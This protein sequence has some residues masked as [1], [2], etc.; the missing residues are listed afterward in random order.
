MVSPLLW[1]AACAYDA[2]L[3]PAATNPQNVIA[4]EVV[5]AAPGAANATMLL[6]FDA[7]HPGPPTGTGTPVTFGTAPAS[8]F[9]SAD[10]GTPSAGYAIPKVP[11]GDWLIN[12][13]MDND[14]DFNPLYPG[15]AGATCGDGIG[16]HLTDLV[17][18][19][20]APV[21]VEGG[22]LADDVTV[23]IG[24]ILST[25]RPAFSLHG[26]G[27][28]GGSVDRGVSGY[29]FVIL[30]ATGVHSEEPLELADPTATEC[31]VFF[32][33]YAQDLDGDGVIDPHWNPDYAAQGLVAVWPRLYLQ[34]GTPDP[35][36][37]LVGDASLEPGESWAS[38]AVTN[39][40]LALFGSIK[41]GEL[42]PM[43]QLPFLWVPAALHT[44]P[45]GTQEKVQDPSQIPA[46]AWT[47]TVVS[48]TGQTWQIP[49]ELPAFPAVADSAFDPTL[50]AGYLTVK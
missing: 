23:V 1:L 31:P 26:F 12:A 20:Q 41:A 7:N 48:F 14:G 34:F 47:L 37:G 44:L 2:P 39:P 32:P 42:Q 43:T 18:Q 16:A 28:G 4:G 27:A 21:H 3:D 13:L 8:A 50:Q 49:N 46:G 38:E 25:E 33:V 29:Q 6:V 36:T 45:D 9:T 40:T 19:E 22:E 35:L 15:L 24:Q 17:T 30:D 5:D 11:D 10:A